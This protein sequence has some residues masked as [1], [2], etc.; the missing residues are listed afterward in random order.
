MTLTTEWHS[1]HVDSCSMRT[2][3]TAKEVGSI[4]SDNII[5]MFGDINPTQAWHKARSKSC[6]RTLCARDPFAPHPWHFGIWFCCFEIYSRGLKDH[7]HTYA[8]RISHL[9]AIVRGTLLTHT[10]ALSP[11]LTLPKLVTLGLSLVK[12][13]R[14]RPISASK[15][16]IP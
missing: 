15:S 13:G 9:Q 3:K 7:Q 10:F 1:L 2:H 4:R 12:W 8:F 16:C 6:P 5:T 14:C 11:L